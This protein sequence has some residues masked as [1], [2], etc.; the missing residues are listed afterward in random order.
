M[1]WREA[2]ALAFL[3]GVIQD[4]VTNSFFGLQTISYVGAALFLQFFSVRF[5]REKKWIQLA[6]LFSATWLVVILFSVFSF[7]IG[8][9]YFSEAEWMFTKSVLI[10]SYTTAFGFVFYPSFEKYLLPLFG[11]RQYELFAK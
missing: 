8:T 5:D 4:L 9:R 11:P 1:N 2:V 10:A 7:A 3:I 6:G